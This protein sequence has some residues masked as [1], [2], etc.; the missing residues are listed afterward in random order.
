MDD[1]FR[2]ATES[3]ADFY[4]LTGTAAATL[5]GL[6]FVAVTLMTTASRQLV[7]DP[8]AGVAAYAAPTVTHFLLTLI[9]SCLMLVPWHD[10]MGLHVTLVVM[11]ASALV[12]SAVVIRRT[13]AMKIYTPV[14]EDWIF[15]MILPF[16][17]YLAVFLAAF[18]IGR[19]STPL[20]VVGAATVLLLV[21]GVHNAW[22]MVTFL[23]IT[24][25]KAQPPKE[26]R[27]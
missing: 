5:T 9:L 1:A 20:F 19:G 3:W 24:A 12:Y 7:A 6:Q 17:A 22:D 13:L 11:G 8:E 14:L 10:W 15:H 2:I 25:I 23:T 4:L 21:V 27:K 26:D 18:F 16:I